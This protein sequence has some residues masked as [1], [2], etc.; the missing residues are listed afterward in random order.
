[1]IV[2]NRAGREV[3]STP[4]I[5]NAGPVEVAPDLVLPG[6]KRP[7]CERV[8]AELHPVMQDVPFEDLTDEDIAF[9]NGET[10]VDLERIHWLADAARWAR[11][12]ASGCEGDVEPVPADAFYGLFR[13]GAPTGRE[14]FLRTPLPTLRTM[15]EDAVREEIV[16]AWYPQAAPSAPGGARVV[17]SPRSARSRTRRR[18]ALVRR[19]PRDPAQAPR[20]RSGGVARSRCRPGRDRIAA[21]G[22]PRRT[23]TG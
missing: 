18:P 20:A 17:A 14:A 22:S 13:E 7:E 11:D 12:S 2:L 23:R 4:I 5:F 3:A 6:K 19:R 8:T 10:G 16:P 21:S 1:M 9:L 15:L